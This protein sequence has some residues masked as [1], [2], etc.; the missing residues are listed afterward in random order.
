MV[1]MEDALFFSNDVRDQRGRL[2]II[3]IREAPPLSQK[4]ESKQHEL[5]P[6]SWQGIG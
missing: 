5:N 6:R 3:L 1:N 2:F 4:A